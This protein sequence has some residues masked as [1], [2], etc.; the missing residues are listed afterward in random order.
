[1]ELQSHGADNGAQSSSAT[2]VP[3]HSSF[4]AAP[5]RTDGGDYLQ[6]SFAPGETATDMTRTN[7]LA[8][9]NTIVDMGLR[10]ARFV[11]CVVVALVFAFGFAL[12]TSNKKTLTHVY[13]NRLA[14]NETL[15]TK[16]SSVVEDYNTLFGYILFSGGKVFEV[17][18]ETL[19]FPTLG[20]YLHNCSLYP[21]DQP[22]RV[23]SVVKARCIFWG[24]KTVII[25]MNV[26]FTSVY[27]GQT[28]INADPTSRRLTDELPDMLLQMEMPWAVDSEADVLHS[29]LRTS[30][31]GVTT[32]FEFE[33]TC[34]WSKQDNNKDNGGQQ[35]WG[36]LADDVD[37]TSVSF[38]FPSHA[39]NSALL[40][41]NTVVPIASAEIPLRDYV[42]NREK[43]EVTPDWD[44]A[45]LYS[46]FRQGMAKLHRATG[47]VSDF[48]PQTFDDLVHVVASELKTA[49]PSNTRVGDLVL[50]LEHQQLAEDV[51]FTSLTLSVPVEADSEG[52]TLC[53]ASGCVYATS[54]SVL[55]QLHMQPGVSIASFEQNDDSAL[56]Y[57]VGNQYVQDVGASQSPHEVLTISVGK[58]SWQLSPLHIRH[59]A[60]C[61]DEDEQQCLGLS[62]PFA[63]G[64][65]VLLA[66][67]DAL[68]TQHAVRPVALV[69][70]RP[71]TILD[72]SRLDN[73][74]LTTWHRLVSSNGKLVHPSSSVCTPL[75]DSYLTHLQ[76]N[77]LYLDGRPSPDMYSSAL[78]Y[79]LQRGV[80]TSYADAV[81]RR[82]AQ[83]AVMA[84]SGSGSNDTGPTTDIEVNVPT[85]TALVTV[86]GCIFIVLL[87][88][89]V[90]YLP[91]SRVKLSPDT[92]PA[93]Q[94]VQILTDDLYPD[95]VHKKR[96]RFANGDCLLFNE[97]VVDAIV[98][99]AKRDQTKKI[100]L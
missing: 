93:A 35:Q 87:M 72:M 78:F 43:Y 63:T 31:T 1:M 71:A 21:G 45:E 66:G 28:T 46:T 70:L 18:C 39:W 69:T 82:L 53:G 61:A 60:A 75:V 40:A 68:A 92:T 49:L 29:I 51:Q 76:T 15:S 97:Y 95:V 20:T 5:L 2:A 90:I 30:V 48:V 89:C 79:L 65:G 81:S 23:H 4:M 24:L 6:Q 36:A 26:G 13:Q 80:P 91:T 47:S 33:D 55:E 7:A 64:D 37:T 94:Y 32:P 67:K 59:G 19:I 77:H 8:D 34:K 57:S 16:A 96:L 44:T 56:V 17:F 25:L 14:A 12:L 88:L 54:S 99:H 98:L 22:A 83:S 62:L 3:T 9:R 86:A 27:V 85:A 73:D 52:T 100:Y 38:S 11:L 74:A 50:R 41:S 42:S 10:L 58:L 84:S